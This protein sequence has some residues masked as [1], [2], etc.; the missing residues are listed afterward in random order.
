[1]VSSVL[2]NPGYASRFVSRGNDAM[3]CLE[4]EAVDAVLMELGLPDGD[5][6]DLIRKITSRWPKVPILVLTGD[7]TDTRILAAIRAGAQGYLLKNELERRL[8]GAVEEMLAGGSP[9]SA[10]AARVMVR[11]VREP[12]QKVEEAS[13]SKRE[14]SV[15][16]CLSRGM[17]YQEA[18]GALGISVNTVRTHVRRIYSKLE[19]NSKVEA[20]YFHS[21]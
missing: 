17:T 3:A 14:R 16:D 21:K 1:M 18:G 9:I 15:L 2:S 20:A 4:E 13:L 7:T 6:I 12:H 11:S 8:P 19:V 10:S 5:G